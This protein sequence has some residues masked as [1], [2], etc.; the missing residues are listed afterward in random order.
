MREDMF[1]IIIE[2]PR[3]GRS[4]RRSGGRHDARAKADP[5]SAPRW[6]PVWYR[7]NTR[8]LNEN[9]APLRRF[10]AARVGRPWDAVWSEIRASL[11]PSSAVQ[12]HVFD[13]VLQY[14]ER[15][16]VMI[17][18]VPHHPD[19][20]G[21]KRDKYFPLRSHGK[22]GGFY[23]CPRTGLFCSAQEAHLRRKK[24]KKRA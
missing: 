3:L 16:P 8:C 9:L 19:A 21:S 11:S 22:W 15:N 12:K 5:E 18:G 24:K 2:R 14:V 13:H 17:D 10:L 1:E 4:V 6:E 20:S 7:G 23:V